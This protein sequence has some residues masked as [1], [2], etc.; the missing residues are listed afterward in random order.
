MAEIVLVAEAVKEALNAASFSQP[1]TAE[2]KYL[3]LFDLTDMKDL[4][5][6]VVPRGVTV[7]SLGR[8]RNQYDYQVDVAVQKKL[9]DEGPADVDPLMSLV[10]EIA[11]H[12]KLKRL[13]G[14]PEAVWTRTE[15]TP[16]YDPE[17][18]NEM[19][20]FTSVVTLTFRVGR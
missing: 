12:F 18:M 13:A 19:R 10:E 11:D 20:Q 2:R 4:H 16:V 5:V 14:Y 17:H 3:P 8:N 9:A 6:T 1:L 15:N 7:S